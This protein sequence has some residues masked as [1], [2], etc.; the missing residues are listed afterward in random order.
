MK[1]IVA[2]TAMWLVLAAPI[3]AEP[4][5][6]PPFL[7]QGNNADVAYCAVLLKDTRYREKPRDMTESLRYVSTAAYLF[8]I[9]EERA[10]ESWPTI[11][12]D[13]V[14]W[15]TKAIEEDLAV[16]R[17]LRLSPDACLDLAA[18]IPEDDPKAGSN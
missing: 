13:V 15:T 12:D 14:Q 9:L 10:G 5:G 4:A 1:R 16:A 3:M 7:Q 11:R 8:M 18:S 2:T 6:K 17:A